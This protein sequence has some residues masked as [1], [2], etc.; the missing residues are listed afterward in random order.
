MV[1]ATVGECEACH[2]RRAGGAWPRCTTASRT[3]SSAP[4][5]RPT[6]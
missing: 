6:A 4:C 1:R 5:R 2:E 3:A